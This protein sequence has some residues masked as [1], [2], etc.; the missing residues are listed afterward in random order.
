MYVKPKS[1][2]YFLFFISYLKRLKL[3]LIITVLRVIL[4]IYLY[5][6]KCS[7]QY[8]FFGEIVIKILNLH[9]FLHL[10]L[11]QNICFF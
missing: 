10:T 6:K 2:S 7:K 8:F 11:E 9:D 5:C 3:L 4:N 1:Q